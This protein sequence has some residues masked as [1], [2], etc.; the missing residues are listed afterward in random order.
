MKTL[1]VIPARYGSTRLPGKPLALIG[2]KSILGRVVNIAQGLPKEK[3]RSKLLWPP[4]MKE[5]SPMQ[6]NVR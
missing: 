6:T 1:I 5:L 4:M 2:G 3:K